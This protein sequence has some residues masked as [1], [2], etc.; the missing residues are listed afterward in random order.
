MC[1][2]ASESRGERLNQN[3][4]A[5]HFGCVG[6]Q[7]AKR[8]SPISLIEVTK[9]VGSIAFVSS[10]QA[11]G[12]AQSSERKFD[13]FSS[14]KVASGKPGVAL[15][16]VASD[17][18]VFQI[19]RCELPARIE[20]RCTKSIRAAWAGALFWSGFHPSLYNDRWEVYLSDV[21]MPIDHAR[22][23][24]KFVLIFRR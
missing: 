10:P 12:L 16:H 19:E 2:Y 22:V 15:D 8:R 5:E 6:F 23:E 14:T 20:N 3:E 13:S 21:M 24:A 11:G 17:Q 1:A 7:L 9:E 4:F 18:C